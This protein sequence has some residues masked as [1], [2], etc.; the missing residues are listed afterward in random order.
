MHG[1]W[2]HGE[3]GPLPQHDPIHPGLDR[4]PSVASVTGSQVE[5]REYSALI[6]TQFAPESV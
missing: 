3:I 1:L 2:F 6:D 5:S 4:Q